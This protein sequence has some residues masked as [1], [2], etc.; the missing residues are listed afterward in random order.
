MLEGRRLSDRYQIREA[1]GGGGMANVYLA[2]DLILDRDVAIK[3]LRLEYS[4]DEEFINRFRREAQS[5]ISL[6]HP[7][8]VNIFDVGEEDDI[9]YIVMEYVPGM[10]LKK[11]IQKYGPLEVEESLDIM[12]QII[13]AITHAHAN[14]IVHRDLK[15]QNILI[16]HSNHVKVTDFGIAMALSATTITHTNSVLGSVHYLSPEQARGGMA[17]KKSDIYSLGIV[18]F[19]LLSGR[20]PFS[21]QSAVSIALKHLQSETPSLRR[22]NPD[23][24][25]SVENVVLKATAKDPF[26]RYDSIQEMGEDLATALDESRRN[27][28]KF[29]IPDDGDEVTKAIPIITN[30]TFRE[31]DHTK[32]TIV[33]KGQTSSKSDKSGKRKATIW[34]ASIFGVLFLAALA[35][36]FILPDL[37]KTEE[38][39]I[40][41]VVGEDYEDVLNELTELGLKV[42]QE[43]EN[44]E[45][46]EEGKVIRTIPKT[47]STVKKGAE[48]TVYSSLGEEKVEFKDYIGDD[49]DQVKAILERDGWT[50]N[51]E[52][53][54]SDDPVGVILEQEPAAGKEVVPGETEV[55]FIVSLGPDK[56]KVPNLIG[57][58]EEEVLQSIGDNFTVDMK[59]DYS[60]TI[61][62]GK[63][64]SQDP[65]ALVEKEKGSIIVVTFSQGPEDLPPQNVEVPVF[66]NMDEEKG[67]QQVTIYIQDMNRDITQV[68]DE[69]VIMEDTDYTITL[70]IAP[71]SEAEYKVMLDGEIY[72]QETVPYEKGD[73]P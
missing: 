69:F 16:D 10:T 57:M 18:L 34:I 70:L 42:N 4:N 5:A 11:Y 19:E 30:D 66:I 24:P 67:A 31:K 23:I 64:I 68:A 56:I 55:K 37:L 44:S 12:Q 36:I 26:H 17:T 3:V 59:Y 61:E 22:W 33:H 52:D 9:Y 7:N 41:N 13:S 27:E 40:P 2:R 21:G 62:E 1:I 29:F 45:D 71:D 8:I 20:L 32:D 35:A 15:P 51:K 43:T 48:I 6:S 39:Q 46:I 28:Q 54:Y 49:Y 63:V 65:T 58:T 47:G 73:Q 53:Q 38:V 50:V 72:Y 60:D 25:Q 14:H